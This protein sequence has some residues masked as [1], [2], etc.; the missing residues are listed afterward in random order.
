MRAPRYSFPLFVDNLRISGTFASILVLAGCSTAE[1]AAPVAPPPVEPQPQKSVEKVV[2][3]SP[4]P[5]SEAAKTVKHARKI[6]KVPPKMEPDGLLGLSPQEV[7][8]K[9]G[10]P[11]QEA[12][13]TLS[14]E[15]VYA[16]PGCRFSVFFYPGVDL[17][18]LKVLKYRS[19]SNGSPRT[20]DS[21][22]CV[23]QILTARDAN[24]HS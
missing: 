16:A 17:N 10:P 14:R 5:V 21:R 12:K 3:P 23:Q 6:A 4:K 1:V 13:G 7:L 9:L 18:S 11:E 24:D 22:I 8:Q 15:W 20:E 2:T 19:Q